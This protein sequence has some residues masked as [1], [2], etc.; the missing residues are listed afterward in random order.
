MY[1]FMYMNEWM[2][3]ESVG[4]GDLVD[5]ASDASKAWGVIPSAV[6]T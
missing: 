3:A 2:N 1:A 5:R 6:H 4:S